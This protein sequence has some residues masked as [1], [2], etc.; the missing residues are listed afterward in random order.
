MISTSLYL[1]ERGCSLLQSCTLTQSHSEPD[2]EIMHEYHFPSKIEMSTE[3]F[4]Y[5]SKNNP[6]RIQ[7]A[8]IT[9]TFLHL[10]NKS[11]HIFIEADNAGIM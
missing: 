11:L 10:S 8:P 1:H 7:K 5:K 2:G 3:P 4:A 9:D 6:E